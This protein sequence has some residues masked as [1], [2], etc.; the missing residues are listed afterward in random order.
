M[1]CIQL[2]TL[3]VIT[4]LSSDSD[5]QDA[6]SRIAWMPPLNCYVS[7]SSKG[8]LRVCDAE[9]GGTCLFV[10]PTDFTDK[11]SCVAYCQEVNVMCIGS[12]DGRFRLW[13]NPREWR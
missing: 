3:K 10:L 2:S 11:I 6:L 12:K 7:G 5:Q 9:H 4:N 8:K 13:K 1:V